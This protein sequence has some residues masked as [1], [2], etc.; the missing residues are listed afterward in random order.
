MTKNFCDVCECEVSHPASESI[1][2]HGR[3]LNSGEKL[4]F[5]VRRE[6]VPDRPYHLCTQCAKDVF[7]EALALAYEESLTVH[8]IV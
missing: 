3:T 6:A 5:R 8:R 2:L 1:I 4:L 7:L